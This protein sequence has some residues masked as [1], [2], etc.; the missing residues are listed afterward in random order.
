MC[1]SKGFGTPKCSWL[2]FDSRYLLGP[3][4]VYATEKAFRQV[5]S[6]RLSMNTTESASYANL[7][8]DS[9]KLGSYNRRW[10]NLSEPTQNTTHTTVPWR[11]LANRWQL[12]LLIN[13][14]IGFK[15]SMVLILY[16][17]AQRTYDEDTLVTARWYRGYVTEPFTSGRSAIIQARFFRSES[18]IVSKSTVIVNRE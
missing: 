3:W 9:C 12:S 18:Y 4:E 13:I 14:P 1:I 2:S 5:Q 16:A 7:V 11:K 6:S 17:Q 10:Q 8:S 15:Q